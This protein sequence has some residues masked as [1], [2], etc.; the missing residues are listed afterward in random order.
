MQQLLQAQV[1]LLAGTDTAHITAALGVG[2]YGATL[3]GE[4]KLLVEAGMTP[5]QALAAATS[6]PARTFHCSDRGL[7]WPG[8]RADLLL[9]E[10]DPTQDIL[11]TRNIVAVWKR[12]VQIQRERGR[13]EA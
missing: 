3:H 11:A 1:P 9:V 5:L 13:Q 7:I 12:G 6:V 10:G 2:A 8:M 4:L